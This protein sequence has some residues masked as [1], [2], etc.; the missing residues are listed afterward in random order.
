MK[1]VLFISTRNPY[2]GRLSGDVIR[3]LKIINVLKKKNKIDVLYLGKK[4][5]NKTSQKGIGFKHPN[6]F[7]KIIFCLISLLRLKP[8]QFGLF[9]SSELKEYIAEN[10][11]QYDLLFFYHIRSAQYCPKNFRGKTVLEMGDLY[12][13]NY[14]QTYKNLNILNPLAYIYLLESILIKKTEEEL[15]TDFDK[16]ILFSKKEI[17]EINKEYK[18]NVFFIPESVNK[19][20]RIFKFSKNNFKILFVGNLNYLPNKLACYD[21]VKNIFPRILKINPEIEFHIIGK[22]SK[23]DKFLLSLHSKVK[24]LGQKKNLKNYIKNAICGLANLKIATGVQGKVLTYMSFGL[25]VICSDETQHNFNK[26]TF[27]YKHKDQLIKNI[28]DL[29]KNRSKSL[30]YSKKSSSFINKYKSNKI[31]LEYLKIV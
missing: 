26:S 16:K 31:N 5:Q 8:M 10:A 27:N 6:F 14:H 25:P 13:K 15:F 2:S 1:K 3:S 22:I 7:S 9:Y 30:K 11:D 20:Q 19:I 23:L 29:K 4:T 28:L 17:D 12:S 18:K 24:V 21:F